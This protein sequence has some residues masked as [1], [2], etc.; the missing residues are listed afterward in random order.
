MFCVFLFFGFGHDEVSKRVLVG[1]RGDL[2]GY[3]ILIPID[4]YVSCFI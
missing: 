1:V 4:I 3:M 2:V